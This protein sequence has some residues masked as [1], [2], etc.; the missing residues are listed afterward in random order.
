MKSNLKKLDIGLRGTL[1]EFKA[2]YTTGFL[3]KHGYMA[4]IPQNSFNHIPLCETVQTKYGEM[5]IYGFDVITYVG[6][7]I[8]S[9]ERSQKKYA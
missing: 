2:T 9:T 5:V 4:Y 7:G 3:R 1:R 6:N 8:W